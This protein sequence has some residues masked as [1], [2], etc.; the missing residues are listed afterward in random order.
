MFAAMQKKLTDESRT[1][2]TLGEGT[3]R[4]RA[5]A[6][7]MIDVSGRL[8]STRLDDDGDARGGLT[9]TRG[10]RIVSRDERERDRSTAGVAAAER[11]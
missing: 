6:R 1:Y 7:A 11:E 4:L 3:A 10:R 8:D 9:T 2:E 5:R